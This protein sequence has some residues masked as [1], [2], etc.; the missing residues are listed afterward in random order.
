MHNLPSCYRLARIAYKDVLQEARQANIQ[1]DV[2][3]IKWIK[4]Y[5]DGAYHE[6]PEVAGTLAI[7]DF[8]QAVGMKM[9]PDWAQ[10]T[11]IDLICIERSDEEPQSVLEYAAKFNTYIQMQHSRRGAYATMDVSS[12]SRK[13]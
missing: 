13:Y 4:A 2:W 7:Q 10:A 1:P 3:Y 6:I 8:V 12:T 9:A 11:Q 5:Y